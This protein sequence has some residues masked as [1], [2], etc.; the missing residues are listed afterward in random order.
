MLSNTRRAIQLGSQ[1]L[2]FENIPEIYEND[3]NL[4]PPL[5]AANIEHK[6]V[7]IFLRGIFFKEGKHCIPQGT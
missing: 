1:I 3:Q 4:H 2:R 6:E 5:L 7:F